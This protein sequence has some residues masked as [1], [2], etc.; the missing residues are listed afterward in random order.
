MKTSDYVEYMVF[1][2][3]LALSETVWTNADKK[4][5]SQFE[6]KL[7]WQFKMLDQRGVNYRKPN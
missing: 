5:W 1:P 7:E 4:D 6:N 3:M 2:R